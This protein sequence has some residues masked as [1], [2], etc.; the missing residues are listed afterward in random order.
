MEIHQDFLGYTLFL[1]A[2]Q[3]PYL[4]QVLSKNILLK[5]SKE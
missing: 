3:L 1:Q 5:E 4:T 2:L